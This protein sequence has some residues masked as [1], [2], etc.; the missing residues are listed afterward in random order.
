MADYTDEIIA[1]AKAEGLTDAQIADIIARTGRP[2]FGGGYSIGNTGCRFR[3]LLAISETAE[4]ARRMQR[5]PTP[6]QITDRQA[7]YITDLGGTVLPG[8]TRAEA[9]EVIDMLRSVN[10]VAARATGARHGVH[11]EIWD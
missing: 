2:A 7:A 4:Q 3:A 8:M 10:A 9:S 6:P 11:G 5:R 1:A